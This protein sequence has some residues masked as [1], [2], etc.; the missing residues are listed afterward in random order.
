MTRR[1]SRQSGVSLIELLVV[2][3]IVAILASIAIPSYQRHVMR[4]N[5]AAARACIMEYSQ[6]ME[7]YYTSNMTY[8]GAAPVLNCSTDSGF[9]AKYTMGLAN[10]GLRTYTI[11]AVPIGAQ[12]T[13]DTQCRTLS[14][15][16]ANQRLESGSGTP[17][18]CW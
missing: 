15:T 12:F 9:A 7:R 1:S 10:L 11:N 16:H 4:T 18:D 13:R 8:V 14:L 3:T 2:V 6:F 5:R 17:A